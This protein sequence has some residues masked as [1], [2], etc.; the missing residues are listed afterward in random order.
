MRHQAIFCADQSNCCRD[1][2]VFAIF[3][4][5]GVRHLVFLKVEF[6][7]RWTC[8]DGRCASTCQISC[9]SLVL[10]RRYGRFSFDGCPPSWIF[11]KFES[12][13]TGPIGKANTRLLAKFCADRSNVCGDMA[14]FQFF[15][16]AAVRHLEFVL[17]L[18][19]PPTKSICWFLSL[20]KIWLESVQQFR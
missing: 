20:C 1:M 6:V 16:M 13:P 19:G 12:L 7:N 10:L 9:R 3:Q 17:C 15:K 14:D 8:S 5:G 11:K 18:F 2:A 4:Y